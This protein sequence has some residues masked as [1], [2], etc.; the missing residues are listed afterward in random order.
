MILRYKDIPGLRALDPLSREAVVSK[1]IEAGQARI[2]VYGIP[3]YT[4]YIA[5]PVLPSLFTP[6]YEKSKAMSVLVYILSFIIIFC[7][8]QLYARNTILKWRVADI[9]RSG[10][11]DLLVEDLKNRQASA[12]RRQA[13]IAVVSGLA[14]V[15]LLTV[16]IVVKSLVV[17]SIGVL[18]VLLALGCLS[19]IIH[20][21][22]IMTS[23]VG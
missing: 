19:A 7:I 16:A 17:M 6:A 2:S 18:A 1:A 23:S 21:S 12:Y 10:K 5:A 13:V 11:L 8:A 3:Y 20:R 4:L 14:A 15:V 9:L 22:S